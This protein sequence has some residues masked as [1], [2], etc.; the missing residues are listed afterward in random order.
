MFSIINVVI[1]LFMRVPSAKDG[2]SIIGQYIFNFST[3][4]NVINLPV[5]FHIV[6]AIS[7]AATILSHLI[8]LNTESFLAK[9]IKLKTP[10]LWIIYLFVIFTVILFGYYG[11]GYDPVDFI[12]MGF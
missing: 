10:I 7:V 12:Y 9:F 2:F 8:E 5:E 3:W 11:P 1:F 6:L 4:T